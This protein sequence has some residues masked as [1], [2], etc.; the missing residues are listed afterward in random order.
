MKTIDSILEDMEN[1]VKENIPVSPVN[2]L[3]GAMKVNTLRG[4]LDNEIAD[5]EAKLVNLE[6]C[7]IE[8]GK[9]QSTAKTL[10]RANEGYADYLKAKAKAKRIEEFLRLAKKRS[11]INEYD[12]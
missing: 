3:E 12:I 9:P 2:W 11:I 4:D 5:F 10:A 7:Y 1:R 8:E 6:A